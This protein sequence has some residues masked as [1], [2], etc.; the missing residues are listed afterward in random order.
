MNLRLKIL[1]FFIPLSVKKEKLKQLF[2][3]T[4]HAFG[5]ETEFQDN[6]PYSKL[7]KS[8]A[9]FVQDQST[10][11]HLEFRD[12][13][14]IRKK[15]YQNAYKTGLELRKSLNIHGVSEVMEFTRIFYKLL[16]INFSGQKSGEFVI[17]N[18]FFADHF[19]PETCNLISSLD[20][21]IAAGL[22]DGK[23]EFFQR[24]TEGGDCC[25]GRLIMGGT[26]R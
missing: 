21:G 7:L 13:S 9:V 17:D 8:Y 22:S 26:K 1:H 15:L 14:S 12:I 19:S 6:F 3:L 11:A 23:L 20:E 24:K 4:A 5:C 25:R 16:G 2:R 10:R 18:C